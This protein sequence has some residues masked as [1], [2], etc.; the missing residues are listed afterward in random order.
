MSETQIIL[1]MAG[2]IAS[3]CGY[4]YLMH[5]QHRKDLKESTREHSERTAQVTTAVTEFKNSVDQLVKVNDKIL[6]KL[7]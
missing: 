3:L 6:D 2:A 4:V 1:G 7:N 5:S